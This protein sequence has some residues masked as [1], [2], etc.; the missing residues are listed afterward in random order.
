MNIEVGKYYIY[1]QED[2]GYSFEELLSLNV[3]EDTKVFSFGFPNWVTIDRLKQNEFP[4]LYLPVFVL[5]V[6]IIW[7]LEKLNIDVS[8]ERLSNIVHFRN[9]HKIDKSIAE[10]NSH[11]ILDT[12]FHIEFCGCYAQFYW[13]LCYCVGTIWTEIYIKGDSFENNI[14]V[15]RGYECFMA[16]MDLFVDYD[17]FRYFSLINPFSNHESKYVKF[18]NNF[19]VYGMCFFMCHEISHVELNHTISYTQG[20]LDLRTLQQEEIDADDAAMWKMYDVISSED[21]NGKYALCGIVMA[22]CSLMFVDST[23]EGGPEHP[24]PMERLKKILDHIENNYGYHEEP[25]AIACIC[26]QLWAFYYKKMDRFPDISEPRAKES[27]NK[28]L[29]FIKHLNNKEDND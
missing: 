22:I 17:S 4:D 25:W 3:D 19:Y 26:I 18:A 11:G 12:Q 29:V 6:P 2:I 20:E 7:I 28:V 1:G 9:S 10:V 13:N 14:E 21:I 15:E 27:F 16:G 24:S 8:N 5:N 23:M